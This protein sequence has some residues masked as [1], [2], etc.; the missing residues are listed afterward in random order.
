MWHS[1]HA[2]STLI[3]VCFLEGHKVMRSEK[4]SGMTSFTV[5][6]APHPSKEGLGVP[7]ASPKVTR[8][9]HSGR[10]HLGTGAIVGRR[11]GW[12]IGGV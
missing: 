2:R 3:T 1:Q 7:R 10:G 11:V 8:E 6:A 4:A 9:G 12:R 5:M